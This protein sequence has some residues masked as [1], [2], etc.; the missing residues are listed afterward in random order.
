LGDVAEAFGERCDIQSVDVSRSFE[1]K[2]HFDSAFVAE[3]VSLPQTFGED[4]NVA[5]NDG[6]IEVE[7]SQRLQGDFGGEFGSLDKLDKGVFLLENAIF[8]Q[9]ATGLSHQPNGRAIDG[10]ATGGCK[11]TLAG[12]G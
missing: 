8:G 5:E 12:G 6:G 9:S 3:L 1:K 4:E 11:E 10:F 7:A 2:I